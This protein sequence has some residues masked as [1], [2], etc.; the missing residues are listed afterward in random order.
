MEYRLIRKDYLEEKT[1]SVIDFLYLCLGDQIVGATV[2]FDNMSS[3]DIEKLLANVGQHTV[4]LKLQ[5]RG[6][7]SPQPGVTYTH[8]VFSL[9]SPDVV[10]VSDP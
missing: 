4:G 10:L 3:G 6:D 8:D 2:Y 1:F 7:R 9:K 5:R